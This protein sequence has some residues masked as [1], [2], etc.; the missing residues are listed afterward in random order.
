MPRVWPIEIIELLLDHGADPTL[1]EEGRSAAAM[2][3]HRGRRDVLAV[4]ERR[5]LLPPLQGVDR[6]IAACARHDARPFVRSP[7]ASPSGVREVVARG[8]KLLA[9]F[10]GTW[11]TEGVRDLLDMGVDVGALYPGRQGV[12]GFV[13]DLPAHPESVQALLD[14]GASVDGVLFPSGYAEVDELLRAHGP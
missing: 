7:R 3:A 9:E 8:G 2:A 4:F 13:L 1:A 5:G 14:A 11:N 10:A 6:L 12:R